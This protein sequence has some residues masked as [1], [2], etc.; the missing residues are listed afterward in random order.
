M[1]YSR[2]NLRACPIRWRGVCI[3]PALRAD[4]PH[5][6][7]VIPGVVKTTPHCTIQRP[8]SS[9]VPALKA[10]IDH[11]VAQGMVLPRSLETLYASI[12]QYFIC[13]DEQGLGGCCA[14]SPDGAN[15]AEVRSL[16][17]RDDLRGHGIGVQLLDACIAEARQKRYSRVYALSRLPEFFQRH[18][19]RTIERTALPQKIERDC[20]QCAAFAHCESTAVIRDIE[21][22]SLDAEP[23][24]LVRDGKDS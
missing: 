14:L 5:V 16:V 9:D 11:A 7:K 22:L 18:G 3:G 21:P 6:L 8:T 2:Q 24:T 19:F 4:A 23:A 13:V 10:L 15:M 1:L 17:V 20:L 12:G